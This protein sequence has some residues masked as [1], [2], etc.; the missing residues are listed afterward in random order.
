VRGANRR[1]RIDIAPGFE[2]GFPPEPPSDESDEEPQPAAAS[3]SAPV[4]ASATCLR[5]TVAYF[6]VN[7]TDAVAP[8]LLWSLLASAT[9]S[10][11]LPFGRPL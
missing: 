5:V 1:S 7:F 11:C 9:L 8:A 4:T 3:A 6:T 10:V 2:A